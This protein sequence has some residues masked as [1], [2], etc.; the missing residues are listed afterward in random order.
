MTYDHG[1][2]CLPFLARLGPPAQSPAEEE[3]KDDE[4]ECGAKKRSYRSDR[5]ALH[6]IGIA[7]ESD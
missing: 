4:G 1:F 7:A 5:E 2:Q 6:A 3:P